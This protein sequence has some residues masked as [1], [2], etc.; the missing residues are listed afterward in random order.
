MDYKQLSQSTKKITQELYTSSLGHYIDMS[1]T[2]PLPFRGVGEIR[3]V[4]LGQDPTIQNAKYRSYIRTTLLL[5]Q[6]GHLKNYLQRIC[7]GLG[8]ELESNVYATNLLKNFFITPPD[9]IRKK[10]PEFSQQIS[11][12][13]IPLLREEISVFPNIPILTLGEPVINCLMKKKRWLLIRNYWGYEGPGNYNEDFKMIMPEDNILER[14]IFPFPHIHGLQK[15]FYS[16]QMD[17]YIDYI[18]N[19]IMISRS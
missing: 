13:W 10:H 15:R 8:I 1:L 3:L 2:A 12:Y 16:T 4:V 17:K 14:I 18:K 7:K 6:P 11:S 19:R 5:D 9:Q